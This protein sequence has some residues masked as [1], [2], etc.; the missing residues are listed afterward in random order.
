[1]MARPPIENGDDSMIY[2]ELERRDGNGSSS[3]KSM[4]HPRTTSTTSLPMGQEAAL[5][6][7][8]ETNA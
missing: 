4:L 7:P 5:R 3:H 2:K 8:A 6:R 1:M